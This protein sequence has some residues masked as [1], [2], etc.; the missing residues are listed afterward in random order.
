MLWVGAGLALAA[1]TLLAFVPRLPASDRSRV[2][3]LS[4]GSTRV[5]GGANGRLRAFAIT[6]IAAS[7]VL[8]GAAMLLKTLLALQAVDTGIDTRRVLS[9]NVPVISYGRSDEQIVGFYREAM[10]KVHELPGVDGV[11]LGVLTPSREGGQFGRPRHCRGGPARPVPRHFS[12]I[13][14]RRASAARAAED[15]VCEAAWIARELGRSST[16]PTIRLLA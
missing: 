5:T 2:I 8:A 14:D 6:Q 1:A 16:T 11:A 7:F 3:I 12:R 4:T 13:R 15:A 10:R 9:I